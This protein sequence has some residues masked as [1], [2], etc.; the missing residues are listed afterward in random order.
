[1]FE[2]FV[3]KPI[4]VGAVSIA[5][6]IGGSGPPLLLLHGYPQTH[7]MWHKIAP[8]LARHFTVVVPDL[9]GYGE[10]SKPESGSDHEAY[11]KRALAADQVGVMKELGFKHFHVAG[12]DR[13]ARVVHRMCLDHAN[14]VTKAALLDIL[15]TATVFAN[16]DKM[17]ATRYFHWFFLIQPNALPE[18]M[19][20]ANPDLWLDQLLGSWA[21]RADVFTPEALAHYRRAF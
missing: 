15:P 11:S 3:T 5:T 8:A 4:A 19:I 6:R 21:G 9:R 2:G 18:R 10:S 12:H 1:M 7:A 16:T 17:L 20:A 13:G 14:A